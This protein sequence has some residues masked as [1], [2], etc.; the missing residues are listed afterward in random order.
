MTR[1]PNDMTP[2]PDLTSV[3]GAGPVRLAAAH[4]C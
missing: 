2:L 3:R 1:K 4:L